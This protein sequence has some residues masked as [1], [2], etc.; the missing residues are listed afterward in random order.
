[1]KNL[2]IRKSAK[3]NVYQRIIGISVYLL[4]FAFVI[5]I[6]TMRDELTTGEIDS[7]GYGFEHSW[8]YPQTL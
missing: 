3:E 1:M 2:M 5:L 4:H 8:K 6:S 7:Y